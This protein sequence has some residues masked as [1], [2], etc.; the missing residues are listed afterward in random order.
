MKIATLREQLRRRAIRMQ[1]GGFRPPEPPYGSWFGRVNLALPGESWPTTEGR[2]MHALFQLDTRE[3]PFRPDGL[4]D[5]EIVAAFIG[6]S[7]LPVDA[8]DGVGWCLRAY[9][10][11]AALVP[12]AQVPS[13]SSI[14]AFPMRP[15]VLEDDFPS[16]ADVPLDLPEAFEERYDELFPN[17]EGFKLGGWPTHVQGEVEWAPAGDHPARP[18]YVLQVDTVAKA[19]WSWGHHGIGYFGRGTAPGRTGEWVL[20]WQSL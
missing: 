1:V 12:L 11:A 19:G 18:R 8:P 2:P 9:P 17:A 4:E 14:R 20:S 16:R 7:E 6:P 15:E 13:G 3:L 5:A 10:G